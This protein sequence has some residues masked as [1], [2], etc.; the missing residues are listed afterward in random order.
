MEHKFRNKKHVPI[1][2]LIGTRK[3][4]LVV[5]REGERLGRWESI[6]CLCDCGKE[7]E[8][9]KASFVR[10]EKGRGSCGCK[11]SD[12]I[13]KVHQA[14]LANKV[15]TEGIGSEPY[16]RKLRVKLLAVEKG[17]RNKEK[18]IKGEEMSRQ[19][20]SQLITKPCH[21]CGFYK[22]GEIGI[23]RKDSKLGYGPDNSLSCCKGCNLA[24]GN[25]DYEEFRA[26]MSRAYVHWGS[27]G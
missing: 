2:S 5:L 24:K 20:V 4:R 16:S 14:R 17:I 7:V 19:L 22:V 3:D 8:M 26:W 6:V 9:R 25:R 10:P 23:D 15:L 12:G 13:R 1:A 21:Y 11:Y 27:K 18:G